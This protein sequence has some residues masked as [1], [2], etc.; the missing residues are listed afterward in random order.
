MP[1]FS[2]TLTFTSFLLALVVFA[3]GEEQPVGTLHIKMEGFRSNKGRAAVLLYRNAAGFPIK[4]ERAWKKSQVHIHQKEGQARFENLPYGV[5]AV[6]ALHD[7]NGNGR[8][9]TNW[10]GMPRE[11]VGASRNARGR[12]GPPRYQ[13]AAVELSTDTLRLS[14]TVDYL[15]D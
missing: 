6:S 8:M 14:I 3:G 1:T 12:F 9:D 5:Y 11:G 4:T 2:K 13:D 7:E 15:F 10:L